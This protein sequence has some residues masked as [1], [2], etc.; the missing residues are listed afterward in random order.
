[1]PFWWL[2]ALSVLPLLLFPFSPF[3]CTGLGRRHTHRAGLLPASAV[4]A[5]AP[6]RNTRGRLSAQCQEGSQEAAAR[7]ASKCCQWGGEA[8]KKR[9]AFRRPSRSGAGRARS[10]PAP[11]SLGCTQGARPPPSPRSPCWA[12][13]IMMCRRRCRARWSE[14]EKLRSQ[15]EQRKGLMPVCLRKCRVSSS[16]RANFQVQPS[17]VHL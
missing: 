1:M 13:H 7:G 6:H 9:R 14:R 5:S 4:A 17:Q 3:L 15:S 11:Q 10:P 8:Q 16:E 2:T 12:P